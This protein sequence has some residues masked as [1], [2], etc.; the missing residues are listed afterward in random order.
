MATNHIN[1]STGLV[2]SGKP[3]ARHGYDAVSCFSGVAP[4]RGAAPF[5]VD[6]DGATW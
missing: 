2:A 1:V 4:V 6:H 3:L 5:S